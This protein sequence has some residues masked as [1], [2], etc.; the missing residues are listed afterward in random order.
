MFYALYAARK[1]ARNLLG[2]RIRQFWD[3][4]FSD[5]NYERKSCLTLQFL[6]LEA[7]K[8]FDRRI[9]FQL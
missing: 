2:F 5:D 6:S 7:G 4:G 9:F 1:F 3:V 8:C